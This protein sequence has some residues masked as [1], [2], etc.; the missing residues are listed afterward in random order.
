[1]GIPTVMGRLVEPAPLQV[2]E[3]LFDPYFSESSFGFRPG[4]GAHDA[5]RQA[6]QYVAQGRSIVVD[7]DWEKFFDRVQPDVLMGRVARRVKDK[8]VLALIGRFLRAGMMQNGVGV[9]REEGMPQGGPLSPLL[10]NIL[11]D[12]LDKEL[13]KRGQQFGRYAA[14]CNSYV[15]SEAAGQRVMASV[16]EFLEKRLKLQV[17]R[18]KSAGGHVRER[19]FLGYRLLEGGALGVAP[20]SQEKLKGDLRE[21]T[22]RNGGQS[23]E[24][25]SGAVNEK[26]TGWVQYFHLARRKSVLE[27]LSQWLRRRG[28]S[29]KLKPCRRTCAIARFLMKAGESER[30]AWL[31][32]LSG[33][34]W[35]RL[36]DTPQ[37]HRAMSLS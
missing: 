31:L 33:K 23:L 36:A 29:L 17:N 4:R 30:S 16:T 34:G 10:A 28:R 14:D 8:R 27:D 35:W 11:L 13:E 7:L 22:R 5:L 9:R 26:L 24:P 2:L 32:A 15:K 19:K 25:V 1:M 21:L 37:A 6:R 18:Q 20:Q 3:P 12:D